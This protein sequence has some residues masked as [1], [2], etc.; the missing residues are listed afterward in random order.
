MIYNFKDIPVLIVGHENERNYAVLL[1][2]IA[3]ISK[4]KKALDLRDKFNILPIFVCSAIKSSFDNVFD[5]DLTDL[6]VSN[7][8]LKLIREKKQILASWVLELVTN[9]DRNRFRQEEENYKRRS[10][11]AC[12]V[13]SGMI[14]SQINQS[15]QKYDNLT[16]NNAKNVGFLN[17]FFKLYLDT[18]QRLC[19]F[20]SDE[21]FTCFEYQGK[22]LEINIKETVDLMINFSEQSL[23]QL[24]HQYLPAPMG[25][26]INNKVAISL[27]KQIEK[28][29][30][31]LNVYVRVIPSEVKEDRYIF[32]L[33]TLNRTKDTDVSKNVTTVQRRMKKYEYFR[34]DLRDMKSIK[35]IVAERPLTDNSLIEILEHQ[36][37]AKSKLK[38]PYAIGFDDNGNMC[39]EDI[40][41]FPHLL[42]GGASNSGKSTAIMS[43]LMSIAFKHRTG[44]VNVL[45][46]DL[47]G[48]E[49]SDFDVFNGQQFLS[50]PIIT[51]PDIGRKAI[52]LLYEEKIRRLKNRNLSYMPH[53]ICVIDEFPRL[54]SGI[55]NKEDMDKVKSAMNELLSSGRHANIHLVLAVQN[56][57]REDVKGSI[58]N[59]TAR[60]A[61]KCAHYQISKTILGRAGAEKLVGRGQMIFDFISERDKILQGSY[62]SH[63]EIKVLLAEIERT[64]DQQNKYPFKLNNL[65][66]TSIS[67]ELNNKDCV[68]FQRKYVK[69]DKTILLEAIMW[70]LPQEKI[71]NSRIQ[72]EY[73]IGN[74]RAVRVLDQMKGMELIYELNGNLGWKVIPKCFEDI[75]VK[76]LNYLKENGVGES[77][78]RAVFGENM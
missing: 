77:K 50:V 64:F 63:K 11:R 10:V 65:D 67:M 54:Y 37:F 34:L 73:Q 53:I 26:G 23:A 7:Q 28:H 18:I 35:L 16:L 62:I 43:L 8:Y 74:N 76:A 14:N 71:S 4:K 42:L 1:R 66:T 3:N 52:L 36:D 30:K 17:Y 13:L 51:E 72:R 32:I 12:N 58:A 41:E 9:N 25:A 38:I 49:R 29:Y 19:T 22:P 33:D 47:L 70:S 69:T 59:I 24:H 46:L 78:I 40:A 75:P 60:I 27:G 45:I 2:E 15:C 31:A 55:T 68:S 57:V 20:P 5:I 61:L 21:K 48:K 6:E 39:I 56:P 44:N